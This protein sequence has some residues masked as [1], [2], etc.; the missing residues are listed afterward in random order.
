LFGKLGIPV[1]RKTATGQP[2][3]DEEVLTELAEDYPLPK[4]L[5]EHRSLSKLKSTYTDKLPRMVNATTGRVHTNYGQ[6][7]AITGRLS[8]N[9]P[10]LQN[11]PVRTPQGREIRKAF[12]A[13]PGSRIVSAD[14]SQI[15]LRIMAH[16][17]QDASLLDAFAKGLDI[18][19]ATAADIFGIPIEDI[20]SE[21]R[22]Y[23]KAVNF[24]L[25]YGMGAFGLA[26]QL[27]IE[28]NAAQQFID[29]Y[30]AR[31]PGVAEYMQQTRESARA[32]GYVET[33]FGRR[34]TLTDI[35]G[36]NGPRRAGAERAA[37]NA[38]MQG[39]AADL[40]KLA[41]IRLRQRAGQNRGLP[42]RRFRGQRDLLALVRRQRRSDLRSR[43]AGTAQ[44][45]LPADHGEVRFHQRQQEF[46][47]RGRGA[48]ADRISCRMCPGRP[49][50]QALD[51]VRQC[52]PGPLRTQ[53]EPELDDRRR[54]RDR[55]G[56]D[57]A[58]A[59]RRFAGQGGQRNDPRRTVLRPLLRTDAAQPHPARGRTVATGTGEWAPTAMVMVDGKGCIVL[60]N[61]QA[62]RV[63]GYPREE[64][65]GQTI[66]KLLPEHFAGKHP[67]SR[68]G[69]FSD[70]RPRPMGIGRDLFARRSDGTEFPVEIGLNPIETE[71]GSMVLASIVDITERRRAQQK[72]ENALK[73]KTVLLNEVHHRVKNNLQVIASMLNLQA[74]H[75]SDPRLR[76]ILGDSQSRVRAMALTHQLLYERK[77]YSRIDLGD[78]LQRLTQLLGSYRQG[79]SKVVLQN[80]LPETPQYLD[81][82]R[83]IPCGLVVNEL[84]SNAFK[85]AFPDERGGTIGIELRVANGEVEIVVAD[86]GIGLPNDFDIGQIKSLGL[87]LVPLLIEQLAGTFTIEPGPGARF[88][89]RFPSDPPRRA[90]PM[91]ELQPIS[92][93]LVEDERVV[94]FD[95][96]NQLQSFGY[97]VGATVASGEQALARLAEV[98]PDL[99]L[100]DIHLEGKMDGIDDGDRNPVARHQ[101]PGH[102][103]HRLRRRRHPAPRPRQPTVSATWSSPGTRANCT[104][105]SRWR[106]PGAR[107]R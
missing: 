92:L 44:P 81:F 48:C 78:Y 50:R 63:F 66:E 101:I 96:K 54:Q 105:R 8:S 4:L 17:S 85:H 61:A 11:I 65:L 37:I 20:T 70:P 67:G 93:M 25:I 77:D 69:F 82:E 97:V 74:S 52:H 14:Y 7:T 51:G 34:L 91:N 94:A 106:S 80:L 55:I 98:A 41:M 26:S 60:I 32:N 46:P 40:I 88:H 62:E 43:A 33:V 47:A 104:R 107:S 68:E 76:A 35:N 5:L 10:N 39:T 30:F 31:Y 71:E 53:E 9:D 79:R 95:L 100:M 58:D 15:E 83:A 19:K 18:H 38:P 21:Q 24:G 13:P 75:T 3:T 84:V 64:L 57:P 29:K 99:V 27:G 1:K 103:S 28:R 45:G 23:T 2:S 42:E 89:L 59:K 72:I 102:L 73:E 36:G 12:I 6:A 22:R 86:D 56:I 90:R 16:I 87:Q 49:S